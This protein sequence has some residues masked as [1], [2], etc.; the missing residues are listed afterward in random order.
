MH[1][2]ASTSIMHLCLKYGRFIWWEWGCMGKRTNRSGSK[3][4]TS[5][6]LYATWIWTML[7]IRSGLSY[8]MFKDICYLLALMYNDENDK[9]LLGYQWRLIRSASVIFPQFPESSLSNWA[10]I[11]ITSFSDT[12]PI[13]LSLYMTYSDLLHT[14]SQHNQP[15][16][17]LICCNSE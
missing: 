4:H 9:K 13:S 8:F 2:C 3:V 14:Q 17:T 12:F 10:Q 16:E 11:C 7:S 15:T 5:C 6:V 1:P